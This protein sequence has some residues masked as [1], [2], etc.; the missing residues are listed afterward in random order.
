MENN[1]IL[2]MYQHNLHKERLIIGRRAAITMFIVAPMFYL[3]DVYMTNY[4]YST[5][6]WRMF[7]VL[8]ALLYFGLSKSRFNTNH[9][10]VLYGYLCLIYS[11]LI[12]MFGVFYENYGTVDGKFNSFLIAG[13]VTTLLII[14]I[15]ASPVRNYIFSFSFAVIIFF[16]VTFISKGGDSFVVSN[17]INP[18]LIIILLSIF[19]IFNEKQSYAEFKSKV[20]LE[21][22]ERDLRN[23]ME[24][25]RQLEKEL[26]EEVTHDSLTNAFNRRAAEKILPK[27]IKR[28]ELEDKNFLVVFIDLDDLKI[29]N[30]KI[31][32]DEGDKYLVSFTHSV[33]QLLDQDSYLFRIGGDEFLIYIE[34][35]SIEETEML[36]VAITE[37]CLDAGVKFS[38]GITM[39]KAASDIDLFSII[40]E[41]DIKMYNQKRLKKQL[42]IEG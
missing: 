39:S 37:S 4:I 10:V 13:M 20:L 22:N 35:Q 33:N 31:G 14:Q 26:S 41:A 11:V 5:F 6:I 42:E 1:D 27:K 19:S 9:K 40:K 25:R 38:Y 17:L 32:H 30:D 29:I 12:M 24:Y 23:E 8:V 28:L 18:A 34:D 3:K 7:P 36:M 16:I 21:L 15:F 2:Q